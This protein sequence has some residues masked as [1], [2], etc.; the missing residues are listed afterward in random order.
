MKAHYYLLLILTLCLACSNKNKQ[1]KTSEKLT[2]D[3]L[4]V[5]AR[6]VE[7]Q[8]N[9]LTEVDISAVKDTF[10]IPLNVLLSSFQIIR[11]ENSDEALTAAGQDTRIAISDHY[12]LINS[13]KA[14]ACK[15]YNRNGKYITQISSIGQGPDEYT[16]GI[17]DM[18][19]DETNNRIYLLPFRANKILV[20]DLEG[21]PQKHIPLAY[22]THKGRFLINP[23]NKTVTILCLPFQDTPTALI[24]TQ[25]LEGNSLK[26]YPTSSPFLIIPSTYDNEIKE[27]LNTPGTIDFYLHNCIASQDTLYHYDKGSNLLRPVLTTK[28]NEPICHYFVELPNYFLVTWYTQTSWNNAFP[29]FPRILIDKNSLKG[30]FVNLKWNMLGN[31]DGPSKYYFDRGYFSAIME[32][33]ELKEQLD[34]ALAKKD[35]LT[36]SMVQKIKELNNQITEDDNCITFIGK[37]RTNTQ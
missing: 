2:L 11:L 24:W 21:H 15:L 28:T 5:I 37:L 6:S 29:N 8:G 10:N 9:I 36:S 1:E 16:L 19:L 3:D 25:D 18:Y 20:F 23:D 17:Y 27:S 4:P 31:I 26:E 22:T 12:L 13:F 34:Q 7:C 30:C 14:G 33:Y 35:Q 32:P